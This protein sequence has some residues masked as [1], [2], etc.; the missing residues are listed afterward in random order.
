MSKSLILVG[1]MGAGKTTIGKLLAQE[2]NLPFKDID[3]IIVERCG[4][5]IPWIFDVEGEAGFRRREHQVLQDVLA[6]EPAVIATGG[7]IV[8]QAEN[9]ELLK[10]SGGVVFLHATVDQQFERTAK[11]KN[12]PLLQQDNP[13]E[14]LRRLMAQREPWYRE[15]ADLVVETGRN[16]PRAVIQAIVHYW[17]KQA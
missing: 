10:K 9:R 12:R 17:R 13:R 7:G 1:P 2:L 16:R 4:A 3:H 15:V 11:D 14:V 8:S 5:D 6:A